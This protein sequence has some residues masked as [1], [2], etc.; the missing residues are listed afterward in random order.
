MNS[1]SH[2]SALWGGGVELPPSGPGLGRYVTGATDPRLTQRPHWPNPARDCGPTPAVEG[3]S[4]DPSCPSRGFQRRRRNRVAKPVTYPGVPL[5]VLVQENAPLRGHV[6]SVARADDPYQ[7]GYVLSD[8]VELSDAT[9]G[10]RRRDRPAGGA[11]GLA[12]TD[13]GRWLPEVVPTRRR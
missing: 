2:S 4:A 8:V 6:L 12:R 13:H 9:S 11:V 5:R 1:G 10:N 7:K 3:R